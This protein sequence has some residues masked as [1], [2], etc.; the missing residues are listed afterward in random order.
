M[1]DGREQLQITIAHSL[2]DVSADAWDK[3]AGNQNPFLKHVF[4]SSLEDA[5]CV[6][7]ETGW[8]P[9][10]VLIKDLN[11]QVQA[12]APMYLKGNSMGEYVFDWNWAEAYERA[13]GNYYP[14]LVCGVPFTPV[15]GPRLLIAPDISSTLGQELKR[16]LA[17]AMA[18][19]AERAQLSSLHVNFIPE[20]DTGIFEGLGYQSRIGLQYHWTNNGYQTYDDFLSTLTSRKRKA[21]KKE[22]QQAGKDLTIQRLSG[23]NIQPH[24]WDAMYQ[25]YMDTSSRKWGR[26]YLNREFFALLGERMADQVVMIIAIRNGEIIAGALNLIGADTLYGRYWGCSEEVRYLHFELC[27]HQAID[28]AI[29]RSLKR[30]EAGAQG[31][32]KIARGYLPVLTHSAHYIVDENFRT[33]IGEF[34]NHEKHAIKHEYEALM[35]DSPYRQS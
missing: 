34:L 20:N 27:Y 8:A 4:L 16:Q 26:P 2:H 32:H 17:G 24:H 33:A 18:G 14:K 31:E 11:D 7:A 30:V 3:C 35:Q 25:F 9:H 12:C 19:V 1:P 21:L 6:S 29:E 23:D 5:G 22:R 13:G 10:H 28:E 15:T